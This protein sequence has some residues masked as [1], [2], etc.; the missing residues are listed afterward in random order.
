MCNKR[1]KATKLFV[2]LVVYEI[3]KARVTNREK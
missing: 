1:V 2:K 3:G